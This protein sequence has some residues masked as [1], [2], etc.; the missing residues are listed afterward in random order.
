[1]KLTRWLFPK[2]EQAKELAD[3]NYYLAQAF[4]LLALY[5]LVSSI[6]KGFV[7]GISYLYW[8]DILLILVALCTFTL[9]RCLKAGLMT[10][11]KQEYTAKRRWFLIVGSLFHGGMIIGFR[12]A[13]GVI[14]TSKDLFAGMVLAVAVGVVWGV[15]F[16][17]MTT[18]KITPVKDNVPGD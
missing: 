16:H 18:H 14:E 7:L 9:W 11:E 5:V 15:T 12:L 6:M 10:F 8:V 4:T 1:M 17:L 2:K 13:R 3:F